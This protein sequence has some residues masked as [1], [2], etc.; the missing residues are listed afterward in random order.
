MVKRKTP[1]GTVKA[2]CLKYLKRR[3]ILAWNNPTGAVRIALDR[4]LRFGL[5]GS[6]DILGILPRGRFLA[7][8]CKVPNGRL[9]P[10]Q[11]QFLDE[12]RGFGGLAVVAKSWTDVDRALR[13]AGYADDGPLFNYK[14]A[15]E[16]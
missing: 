1:E 7:V 6:S 14:T 13:E 3:G 8:E 16:Q 9:S 15:G 4:W 5:K 12:I 10:E 2:A 11:K